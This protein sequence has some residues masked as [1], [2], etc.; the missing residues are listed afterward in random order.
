[1]SN[2]SFGRAFQATVDLII[3]PQVEKSRELVRQFAKEIDEIITDGILSEKTIKKAQEQ[4]NRLKDITGRSTNAVDKNGNSI[5]SDEDKTTIGAMNAI[6][7][8]EGKVATEGL[9]MMKKT[10]GFLEDIHQRLV[11][12]SPLLR[13]I[14]SLFNLA[15]QLFFM[16]L[17]NKLAEVMIPAVIELVD[18]VTDLWSKFEGKTLG[19]ILGTMLE[20]GV[21]IFGGYFLNLAKQLEN[22][23][24]LL[25]SI[26]TLLSAIG[27]F[28]TADI[29]G[30]LQVGL[31]ILTFLV[32]HFKELIATVVAFKVASLANQV[33]TMY[34]I[35]VSGSIAGKAGAGIGAAMGAASLGAVS[36]IAI[37]TGAGLTAYNMMNGESFGDAALH[38]G[39]SM[40]TYG[41][42][43]IGKAVRS[44]IT[45]GASGTGGSKQTN[46]HNSFYFNGLTD[47]QLEKK[48]RN[49]TNEQYN[50]HRLQSNYG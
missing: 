18:Q 23:G 50:N 13:T 4:I 47:A 25:G 12:A 6:S 5:Y 40:V 33:A 36:S 7:S 32:E 14:E 26:S 30:V 37:G 39:A 1:M 21:K 24:G 16:P 19:Q 31:G 11:S 20:E 17:G 46:V 28:I 38:T 35:G 48:V 22:E 29:T 3:R 9:N 41:G 10:V 43:D 42:Y 27:N 15:V 49:I 44:K 8:A 34:V 45:S 2:Y